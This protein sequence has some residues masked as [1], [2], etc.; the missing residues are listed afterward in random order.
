MMH[1]F[2]P[3]LKPTDHAQCHFSARIV[4]FFGVINVA[5]LDVEA[6]NWKGCTVMNNKY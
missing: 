5:G 3:A 6:W 4:R 1:R 2:F